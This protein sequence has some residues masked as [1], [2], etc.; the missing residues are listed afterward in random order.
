MIVLLEIKWQL[1]YP[2]TQSLPEPKRNIDKEFDEAKKLA[3]LAFG[4][5]ENLIAIPEP[6][7]TISPKIIDRKIMSRTNIET[8]RNKSKSKFDNAV[9]NHD[10]SK[11]RKIYRDVK[12]IEN[13]YAP[14]RI[15]L[16]PQLCALFAMKDNPDLPANRNAAYDY[17]KK[18]LDWNQ[19]DNIS[20]IAFISVAMQKEQWKEAGECLMRLLL[21]KE[22][23]EEK[24]TPFVKA[25]DAVCLICRLNLCRA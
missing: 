1:L 4:G 16:L 17:L 21:A 7:F 15:A 12:D 9:K 25:L 11:I 3:V 19:N 24:D 6:I 14:H 10:I 20:L 8:V 22:T 13:R 23:L 2:T 18:S 5:S